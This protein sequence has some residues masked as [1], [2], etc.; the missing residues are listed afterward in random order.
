[1]KQI[2]LHDEYTAREF[3]ETIIPEKIEVV[4]SFLTL[5]SVD[6]EIAN[7]DVRV[8]EHQKEIAQRNG[9]ITALQGEKTALQTKRQKLIDIGV[10]PASDE[11][12]P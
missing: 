10:K 11:I 2:E 3:E 4:E 5:S 12:I 6:E 8:A 9:L 1:M 7:L